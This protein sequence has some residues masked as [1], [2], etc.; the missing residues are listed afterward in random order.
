[1]FRS[2]E[3]YLHAHGF[4]STEAWCVAWIPFVCTLPLVT[5]EVSYGTARLLLGPCHLVPGKYR[6]REY[7]GD[8][9]IE[10]VTKLIVHE[11][12]IWMEYTHGQP[13]ELG[14]LT[15]TVDDS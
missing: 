3:W 1:M 4:K 14:L 11:M 7:H 13:R 15:F 6:N 5:Y 8:G 12:H 2:H 10:L 9:L